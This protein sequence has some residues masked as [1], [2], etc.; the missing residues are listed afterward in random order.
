MEVAEA[1]GR[2]RPQTHVLAFR[3]VRLPLWG[4]PDAEAL[5]HAVHWA[6]QATPAHRVLSATLRALSVLPHAAENRSHRAAAR[7]IAAKAPHVP[8]AL[9]AM[10]EAH[11]LIASR[12]AAAALTA[13]A[14]TAAEAVAASAAEVAVRGAAEEADAV[15]AD[16]DKSPS[17]IFHTNLY[18]N[19][20]PAHYLS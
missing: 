1:V 12:R 11:V 3:V 2:P 15:S 5:G 17:Q 9:S 13:V 20:L 16:G 14:D 4:L 6:A 19:G 10:K 7:R 8:H 18:V